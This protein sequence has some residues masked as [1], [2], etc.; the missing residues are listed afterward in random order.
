MLTN[1]NSPRAVPLT[2]TADLATTIVTVPAAGGTT[3]YH[4]DNVRFAITATNAGPAEAN[5][6]VIG[7]KP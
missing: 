5:G 1:P 2:A 7:R 4:G 6:A 3:Y